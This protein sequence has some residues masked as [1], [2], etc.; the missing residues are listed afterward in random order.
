MPGVPLIYILP[1]MT[2]TKRTR[3]VCE[4]D[5]YIHMYVYSKKKKKMVKRAR[6]GPILVILFEVVHKIIKFP[7]SRCANAN[8]HSF[9]DI[10]IEIREYVK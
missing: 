2:V 3:K 9:F 1:W 6:N 8:F 4:G 7:A 10:S 5:Y